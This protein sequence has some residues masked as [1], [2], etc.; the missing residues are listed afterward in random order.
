MKYIKPYWW[1][2]LL[3]PLLMIMEVCMDLLQPK[4]MADIVNSGVMQGDTAFIMRTGGWMLTAAIVGLIGGIGCTVFSS[5]AAIRFGG[6]LRLDLFKK[7]QTFSFNNLDEFRTSSLVNR[8]TGDVIQMQNLVQTAL[9]VFVRESALA[10]GSIV[11][12]F[13]L[14]PRLAVIMLITLPLLALILYILAKLTV[15]LFSA[16]QQKLDRLNTVLQENLSGIRVVKAFVRAD[17][18]Q[19]RFAKANQSY[20]DIAVKAAR[21]AAIG[22]PVMMFVLNTATVAV[23]WYGGHHY[24]SGSLEL[25]NLIA[26]VNYMAQLLFALVSL[27][28]MIMMLSRAKASAVRVQEVLAADPVITDPELPRDKVIRHGEVEFN[29]VSFTYREGGEGREVLQN[30]NLKIRPRK[31]V[32]ILGAT[33]SGKT[34][35]VNLIPRLYEAG[36]GEVLI[37]GVNVNRIATGHLRREIGVVLQQA[38]LFSGSI[39]DNIRFGKPE[40]GDDE[41]IAAAQA[42]Q[43][44]EFISKLPDGYDTVLGQRGIN[45]SGGQ[46]Q[47]LSIA[48]ALLLRPRI[49]ILDDST[50]AVDS[51]T[52]SGIMQALAER[53]RESTVI[54][55]AQRISSVRHADQIIVL[56]EGR[57]A[58]EGTHE[59][60]LQSNDVYRQ[61]Y[62]SQRPDEEVAYG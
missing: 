8:L 1:A 15:P 16:V 57:I 18:E 10:I 47:R 12:A 37:D 35:L 13:V 9:R 58:G 39:R 51:K 31:M 38:I 49:L 40:A 36:S 29:R 45:L 14:S 11:M 43:A 20:L 23:L 60:L 59:E 17:Y 19:R 26:F 42:A 28:M 21:T 2:A 61:I 33:G 30:I 6:A 50:S 7:V 52:E 46:K 25:G 27:G 55:I 44:H 5:Y 54:L 56:D 41:V 24:W 4:L 22:M 32:G 3:A 62:Q 48:R 53:A 34:S